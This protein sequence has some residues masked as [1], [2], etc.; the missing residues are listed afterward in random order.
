MGEMQ[1]KA[2]AAACA[3]L[4]ARF[5]AAGIPHEAIDGSALRAITDTLWDSAAQEEGY[6]GDPD[7]DLARLSM[8]LS[9]DYSEELGVGEHAI[10]GL[11]YAIEAIRSG[12]HGTAE[13][14][15]RNLYEAVDYDLVAS[16]GFDIAPETAEREILGSPSMQR[17]LT[18]IADVLAMAHGVPVQATS[19]SIR[20]YAESFS[21]VSG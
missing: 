11:Y 3:E 2:F 19:A 7:S 18:F 8:A 21:F 12:D 4:L 5:F 15:A 13:L 14:V 6:A 17:I 16:P 20:N 9:G 10:S 1:V